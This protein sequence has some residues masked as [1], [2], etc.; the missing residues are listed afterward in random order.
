MVLWR[1]SGVCSYS[2][3]LTYTCSGRSC[4]SWWFRVFF[5][6]SFG[7]WVN[8]KL[9]FWK[10]W[11]V[12]PFSSL[13][14]LYW[15]LCSPFRSFLIFWNYLLQVNLLSH[16]SNLCPNLTSF[17]KVPYSVSVK[18]SRSNYPMPPRT[19]VKLMQL[20]EGAEIRT[21]KWSPRGPCRVTHFSQLIYTTLQEKLK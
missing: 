12:V 7:D 6:M 11:S 9:L 2:R 18:T 19:P 10:S 16:P 13:F 17:P 21:P 15:L 14:R 8:R 1:F 20:W 5:K 4:L 3:V